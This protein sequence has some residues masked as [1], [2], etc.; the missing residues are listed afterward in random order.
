MKTDTKKWKENFNQELVH[1]QIQFDSFFTEGKMDDYYTLKEDRKA[2]ML[3]LNISAHNELPKQI[4][5]ELIDAFNKSK[6]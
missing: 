6:P 4:E 3:I 1:I 2:G 5:E